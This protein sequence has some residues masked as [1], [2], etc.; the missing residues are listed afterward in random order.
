MCHLYQN[1]IIN[2]NPWLTLSQMKLHLQ[3]ITSTAFNPISL[4]LN[5]ELI[6]GFC[7][8][9]TLIQPTQNYWPL[10]YEFLIT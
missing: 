3:P 2:Y 10:H 6:C 5:L 1:I 4:S 8:K 7:F 9:H